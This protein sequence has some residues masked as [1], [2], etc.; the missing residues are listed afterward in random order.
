MDGAP[1]TENKNPEENA[2]SPSSDPK[3]FPVGSLE[4]LQPTT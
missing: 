4:T 1:L 3:Q 2:L